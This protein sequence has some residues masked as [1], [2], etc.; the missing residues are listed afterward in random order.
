MLQ[1]F[2]P[3]SRRANALAARCIRESF[4]SS[5]N[6]SWQIGNLQFLRWP[7]A[8]AIDF[9]RRLRRRD[10]SKASTRGLV[11]PAPLQDEAQASL[12]DHERMFP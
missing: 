1:V 7:S 10:R 5:G 8:V 3:C 4:Q 9:D 2:C 12:I 11:F 6:R